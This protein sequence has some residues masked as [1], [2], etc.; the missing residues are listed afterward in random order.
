MA[1]ELSS[2]YDSVDHA[3]LTEKLRYY[4][5]QEDSCQLLLSFSS[6]RTCVTQVQRFNNESLQLGECGA[7]KGS[8]FYG[9]IYGISTNEVVVLNSIMSKPQIYRKV[10]NKDLGINIVNHKNFPI[11]G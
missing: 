10:T 6:E 4:G 8:K 3:I 2:A 7:V 11:C 9:F 5:V 1:T